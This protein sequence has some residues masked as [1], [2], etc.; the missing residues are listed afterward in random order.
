MTDRIPLADLTSDQLDA[1]Y[2]RL[3]DDKTVIT[4]LEGQEKRLLRAEAAIDRVRGYAE[5]ALGT[6]GPGFGVSLGYLL[7]LLDTDPMRTQATQ[8]TGQ[9]EPEPATI[10]DPE[11][12]KQQYEAAIRSCVEDGNV[13]YEHLADAVIRVRDRHLQQLR[14][15]L[16]LADTTLREILTGGQITGD[17]MERWRAVLDELTEQTEPA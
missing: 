15:R 12:L 8:A 4:H 9:P 5:R 16:T 1:L 10:T 17:R 13:R 3:E 7:T 2:G 6:D 11:W 14:Q